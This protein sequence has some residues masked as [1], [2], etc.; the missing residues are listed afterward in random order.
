MRRD[1]LLAR[2][3]AKADRGQAIIGARKGDTVKVQVPS[4]KMLE[5]SVLA[6]TH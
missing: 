3:R 1:E 6:I 2:L 5:Y 4:G